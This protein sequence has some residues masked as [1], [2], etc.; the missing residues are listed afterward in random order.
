M[1]CI[2]LDTQDPPNLTNLKESCAT[3][4]MVFEN[5]ATKSFYNKKRKKSSIPT[6]LIVNWQGEHVYLGKTVKSNDTLNTARP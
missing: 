5:T 6:G 3:F 1:Y 4:D 2:I